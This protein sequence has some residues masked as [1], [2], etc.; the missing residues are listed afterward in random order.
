MLYLIEL[1]LWSVFAVSPFSWNTI[2]HYDAQDINADG[3]IST[4]EPSSGSPLGDWQDAINSFT[5]SQ[6]ILS[7]QPLY[8]SGA[9]NGTLPGILFDG[10]NDILET[11][12]EIEINL[13]ETFSE[14]SFA[15]VI[16][17]GT[18][19][20]NLQ[21]I[22]EQGT[23]LKWYAF[24]ISGWR[25][26]GWVWNTI[27]WAAPDQYK[28]IDYG[29]INPN[30]SYNITL[31]HDTNS[32]QWYLDGILINTLTG[33]SSQSI[34]GVCRFD[35]FF[36]CSLYDTGSTI[37]IGATQ[38]DTLNLSDTSTINLYQW[39]YF[40]GSIWEILSWDIALSSTQVWDVESYFS[41]W[42]SD[43][44]PPSIDSTSIAS[45]SLLPWW[46][47]TV[48][49]SYSDSESDIDVSSALASLHKWDEI[50]AWWWDISSSNLSINSVWTWSAS[51]ST[52]DLIFW[53]YQFRFMVDDTSGNTRA[54]NIDF[55]I[56]EPEFIV[57]TWSLDIGDIDSFSDYYS[58]ELE[59]TVRT[60]WAGHRI[61]LQRNTDLTYLTE[62]ISPFTGL[63][64]WYDL[65]PV[66]SDTITSFSSPTII[67]SQTESINVNG[68]KNT[69]VYGIK[70]WALIDIQQAAGD[71]QWLI[72]LSISLDY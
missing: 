32:L 64:Y 25:L 7:S 68:N 24:Q 34:H 47:H 35:T 45:G 60:L 17:T 72:D 55:Y 23:H 33:A 10:T 66:Y 49:M 41:R 52:N 71:Y 39:N 5:C 54:Q 40:S 28:I 22:Y 69:Y 62:T 19:I 6:A 56:D 31:V 18:N 11:R 67:G 37:G 2:F 13:D 57:S 50:S 59:I 48:V 43:S 9:I 12:D 65:G 44:T 53:K 42:L 36:W 21:T 3:D 46:N 58:D 1:S 29:A 38:N 4:W 20:T 26:Y 16:E 15:L 63:G 61:I 14:K 70:I 30:T 51:Y 8:I 27:D